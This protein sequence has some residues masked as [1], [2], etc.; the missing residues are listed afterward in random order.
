VNIMTERTWEI[1][2]K[3]AMIPSL[4]GIGLFRGKLITLCGTLTQISMSAHGTSTEED[5]E[6]V[7]FI[8]NKT[9][10]AMLL[11]KPWIEKDQAR[12]KEEEVSKQKKQELKDFM[13]RRITH[14]I[15]EH[16]NRSKLFRTRNLDVKFERTHED[17]RYLSIQE[18]RAPTL[19][20]EEVFPL[21]PS[22]DHQQCEFT[23]PREDQNRKRNIETK[24][25]EKKARKINKNKEKIEKL[26]KVQEGTAQKEGF[27]NLNFVGIPAQH[28]MALHHG[29]EI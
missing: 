13:T 19:D 8:E 27:Q 21:N 15:E 7:K 25:I 12:R 1:L 14:L 28:S 11:G 10:F 22:K 18:S 20:R 24:I 2:G 9:P 5:F 4:G 17:L 26:Q 29:E 6:V 3:H 23:I 16:E